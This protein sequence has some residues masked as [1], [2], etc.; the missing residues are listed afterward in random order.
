M[1]KFEIDWNEDWEEEDP[2]EG[3]FDDILKYGND[4]PDFKCGDR[5]KYIFNT[6]K[7]QIGTV[8][9]YSN[10]DIYLICFDENIGGP[11]IIKHNIPDGHC[12]HINKNR[13]ELL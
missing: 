8:V 9:K 10:F 3:P 4:G 1:K 11:S 5:V 2:N 6:F 7:G 12:S 13:I